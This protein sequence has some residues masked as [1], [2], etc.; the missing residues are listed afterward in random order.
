MGSEVVRGDG[1]PGLDAD[2]GAH[3]LAEGMR[4]VQILRWVPS[5]PLGSVVV[6]DV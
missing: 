1:G 4:L 5:T 2:D 3:L 6:P